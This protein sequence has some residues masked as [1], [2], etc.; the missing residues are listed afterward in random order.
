MNRLSENYFVCGD[1]KVDNTWSKQN[2]SYDISNAASHDGWDRQDSFGGTALSSDGPYHD[3]FLN[4]GAWFAGLW[5]TR[6][7][8]DTIIWI[9]SA[10]NSFIT[11]GTLKFVRE[12]VDWKPVGA[13]VVRFSVKI[14]VSA[15]VLLMGNPQS[16]GS[17]ASG[18]DRM[19]KPH[20]CGVCLRIQY[21]M[22]GV[23][24]PDSAEADG[25]RSPHCAG[26]PGTW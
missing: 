13:M 10:I 23:G 7:H 9:E 12:T 21:P 22:A 18:E 4:Q 25:C 24:R 3:R 6:T 5:P 2:G 16:V 1:C 17:C 8:A 20:S 11:R 14:G 15:M 26:L 19:A